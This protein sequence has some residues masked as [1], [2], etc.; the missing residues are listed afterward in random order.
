MV[1]KDEKKMKPVK[2]RELRQDEDTLRVQKEAVVHVT[3]HQTAKSSPHFYKGI[4]SPSTSVLAF[5]AVPTEALPPAV[6]PPFTEV[7]TPDFVAMADPDEA[8]CNAPGVE[9]DYHLP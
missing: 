7:T 6:T 1:C 8:V 2:R 4:Q 5:P 9:K 3:S